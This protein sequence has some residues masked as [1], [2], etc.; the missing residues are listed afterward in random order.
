VSQQVNSRNITDRPGRHRTSERLQASE[1]YLNTFN[2]F[3]S[4]SFT[5]SDRH[6]SKTLYPP[7]FT[8]FTWQT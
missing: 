6:T 5:H 4:H 1:F 8:P 2:S 7:L 3:D